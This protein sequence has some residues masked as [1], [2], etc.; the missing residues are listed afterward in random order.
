VAE[1][2][3][4]T[5]SAVQAMREVAASL[6][7]DKDRMG[8]NIEATHGAMLSERVMMRIAPQVGRE[9]AHE[10]LRQALERARHLNEPLDRAIGDIPELSTLLSDEDRTSLD[11]PLT[12]LGPADV[13]RRR[14]LED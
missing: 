12:Y 2:L 8:A 6:E 10:L 11:D 5:M 3:R 1:A 14:L 7:V 13:F 9:R 4:L